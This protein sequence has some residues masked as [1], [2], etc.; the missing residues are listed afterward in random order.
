MED[1]VRLFRYRQRLLYQ[2]LLSD[3]YYDYNY[4]YMVP[5]TGY[6]Q[7]FDLIPYK[8]GLMLML[9]DRSEPKPWFPLNPGKSCSIRSFV[10]TTGEKR[11]K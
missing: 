6:L 1:K 5:N 4:G 7:Y 8:A 9:P 3:G 2:C 10:P 11:W